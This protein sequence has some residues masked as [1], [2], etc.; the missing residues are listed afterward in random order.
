MS[1]IEP[2]IEL[3]ADVVDASDSPKGFFVTLFVVV[4]VIGIISLVIYLI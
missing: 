3:I 1:I 2:I 4:V